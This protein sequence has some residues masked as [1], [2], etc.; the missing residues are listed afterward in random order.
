[1]AD[2][3]LQ[4]RT[5][6]DDNYEVLNK[7][8]D[9]L[10]NVTVFPSLVWLWCWDVIRNW[11]ENEQ[12]KDVHED[13]HVDECFRMD[14]ELKEIWD[15]FWEDSD[16]NGFTLEYGVEDL[17]EGL[18]D[19]LRDNDFIVSLDEDGWLDEVSDDETN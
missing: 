10:Q 4:E 9:D 17:D 12:W 18:R 11:Y 16:K 8:V 19:W 2:I 1:M 5:R 14:L 13:P 15:K 6:R 7:L 3:D